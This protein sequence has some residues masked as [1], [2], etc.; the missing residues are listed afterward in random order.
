MPGINFTF[1]RSEAPAFAKRVTDFVHTV[2]KLMPA[3]IH[4]EMQVDSVNSFPHSSG[5]ASSA[6]SISSL[7]LCLCQINDEL[8][9]TKSD[10]PTFYQK[11]SF[12]SRL[13]SGSACRSVYGSW[14]LW[15]KLEDIADSSDEQGLSIDHLIHPDFKVMYDAILIVNSSQ[16]KVSSRTGQYLMDMNP[17]RDARY[18]S[19]K[20]NAVRFI[21]A[22]KKGDER[23]FSAIVENEAASLHAMLLTSDPPVIMI[24]PES[25]HLIE[26]LK[27]FRINSGLPFAYTLDAGP[28][29]HILY[30]PKIREEMVQFIH[31]ELVTFC[32]EGKWI[33]DVAGPGPENIP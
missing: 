10:R 12:L 13:G 26:K 14:V 11:A 3:L 25:L 30:P 28:N 4:L 29:I 6:S 15:G 22:L 1:N 8:E 23:S 18:A 7:V 31:N 24:R 5:I 9:E 17:Y 33:D 27:N 21:H 32:E 20:K 19:A 2:A 16:K